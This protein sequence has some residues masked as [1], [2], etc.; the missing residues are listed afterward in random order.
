MDRRVKILKPLCHFILQPDLQAIQVE[1]KNNLVVP[2]LC[3]QNKADE[4][5]SSAQKTT[6]EAQTHLNWFYVLFH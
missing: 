5:D 6:K 3:M 2:K 4:D 1:Q